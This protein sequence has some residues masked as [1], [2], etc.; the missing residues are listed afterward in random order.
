M[1]MLSPSGARWLGDVLAGVLERDEATASASRNLGLYHPAARPPEFPSTRLRASIASKLREFQ[2]VDRVDEIIR[3]LKSLH[4]SQRRYQGLV[5]YNKK[6]FKINFRHRRTLSMMN[7]LRSSAA[8]LIAVRYDSHAVINF[9]NR[10]ERNS[11]AEIL[12][13]DLR[14]VLR[15]DF[16]ARTASRPADRLY[17][18][19]SCV[20]CR[21]KCCF[22]L[23][24]RI[25]KGLRWQLRQLQPATG[26]AAPQLILRAKYPLTILPPQI[27]VL[28]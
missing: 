7:V 24:M 26:L 28:D 8:Y 5:R 14:S 18:E 13:D 6:R 11:L 3:R 9:F 22:V 12:L 15:K 27:G 17:Q 16:Q 2:T 19:T 20:C 21:L 23:S 25:R 10:D 1:L 4:V